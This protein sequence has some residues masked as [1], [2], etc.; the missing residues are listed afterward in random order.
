LKDLWDGS[1][2][3]TGV[4]VDGVGK[5]AVLVDSGVDLL[6]H[7]VFDEIACFENVHGAVGPLLSGFGDLGG[8]C[9]DGGLERCWEDWLEKRDS[10]WGDAFTG[11]G[12]ANQA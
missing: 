4:V 12:A 5:A 2:K 6:D 1:F 10:C 3:E 9:S 11:K 7:G 8:S